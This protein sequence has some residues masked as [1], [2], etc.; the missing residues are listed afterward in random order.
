MVAH[1]TSLTVSAM[2]FVGLVLVMFLCALLAVAALVP[3]LSAVGWVIV[4][5]GLAGFGLAAINR[6][7]D[8]VERR[9]Q[10]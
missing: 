8:R 1:T 6:Y 4:V 7:A 3:Q 2:R 10:V 9:R 5:A